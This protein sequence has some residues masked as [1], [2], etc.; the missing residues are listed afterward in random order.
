MTYGKYTQSED[1]FVECWG[2]E[3]L[4][5]VPERYSGLLHARIYDPNGKEIRYAQTYFE[6]KAI[7]SGQYYTTYTTLV[8]S[9]I[10]N[11][12]RNYVKPF[13]IDKIYHSCKSGFGGE[14]GNGLID[15]ITEKPIRAPDTI[16]GIDNEEYTIRWDYSPTDPPSHDDEEEPYEYD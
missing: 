16:F 1:I 11:Y 9:V 2:R 3:V 6:Q 14:F 4:V 12:C 7:M 8:E 10:H 5:K 13:C 15:F